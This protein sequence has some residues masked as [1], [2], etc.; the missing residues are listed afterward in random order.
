MQIFSA[1]WRRIKAGFSKHVAPLFHPEAA[2]NGRH[3]IWQRGF[4]E[5]LVRNDADYAAHVAYIH[6]N[7]VKHGHVGRVADWPYSSSHRFVRYGLYPV[8]WAGG[9]KAPAGRYGEA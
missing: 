7:P 4:W 3:G 9:E 2:R 1:R 8:D 6:Y 5:H